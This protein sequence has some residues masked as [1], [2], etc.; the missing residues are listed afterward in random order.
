MEWERS[1]IHLS[2][3]SCELYQG[4]SLGLIITILFGIHL[5]A[6]LTLKGPVP[7]IYGR[8]RIYTGPTSAAYRGS[9]HFRRTRAELVPHSPRSWPALEPWL[10]PIMGRRKPR[11]NRIVSEPWLCQEPQAAFPVW[12]PCFQATEPRYTSRKSCVHTFMPYSTWLIGN[13]PVFS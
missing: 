6:I 7:Y 11:F 4:T 9:T 3:R 12:V 2:L 5:F 1:L 10:C 8:S 13:L